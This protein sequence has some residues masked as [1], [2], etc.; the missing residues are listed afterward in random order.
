MMTSRPFLAALPRSRRDTELQLHSGTHRLPRARYA[1][2]TPQQWQDP[3]KDFGTNTLHLHHPGFSGNVQVFVM[4]V[5][6]T[7]RTKE[8]CF[9]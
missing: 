7:R 5:S 9:T 1:Q 6:K 4:F 3:S 2:P 8:P